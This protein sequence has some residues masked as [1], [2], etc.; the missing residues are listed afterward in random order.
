MVKAANMK[1]SKI[2]FVVLAE[3]TYDKRENLMLAINNIQNELSSS[4]DLTKLGKNVVWK[5]IKVK[6]LP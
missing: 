3:I 6:R 2:R 5:T 4:D 1:T